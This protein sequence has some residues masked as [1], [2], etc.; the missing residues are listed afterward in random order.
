MPPLP[1]LKDFL[2]ALQQCVMPGAGAAA[3]VTALFLC[4]GRWAAALGS[5]VAVVVA[6]MWGNFTLA[7]LADKDP[8]PTWEN[9][10]RLLL[11]KPG[12]TDPGFQWLPRAALVLLVVGLLSRWLGTA[13]SRVLPEGRWW[14][15]NLLVW[16][17][18]VVAVVVVSAWLVLGHAASAPEWA[19]LRWELAALM[20]FMWLVLDGL[21]REGLGGEVSAHLTAIL[22]AASVVLLY[23]HNAKFMELA[24]LVGS[25]M[26]GT[27]VAVCAVPT[28]TGAAKIAASGAIPAAVVFLPGLILGTR[29]AHDENKVPALCFWLIALTPLVL[30][31]FLVPRISR[32]NHWLLIGLRV[33]LVLAPLAVAVLYAGQYEKFPFEEEPQW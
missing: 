22:Y 5:A 1:P 24:V 14:A 33:L 12:E 11:W 6:F 21:A 29:P 16:F 10:S 8:Q 26:F 2:E 19:H 25:A 4:A 13:M 31:P 27:A 30:A 32:R 23:S 20:L 9:T 3:L 18:R 15:A 7:H 17:P 28:A